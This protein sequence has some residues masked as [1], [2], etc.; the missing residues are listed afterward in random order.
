ML[1]D[2]IANALCPKGHG[3]DQRRKAGVEPRAFL[4][5]LL[6]RPKVHTKLKAA[7]AAAE[8][9]ADQQARGH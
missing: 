6:E 5:R 7:V 9:P 3:A 8:R 1:A 2:S 4:N